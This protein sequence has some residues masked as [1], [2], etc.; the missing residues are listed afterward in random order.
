MEIT[1]L[2]DILPHYAAH[3]PKDDALAG[4]EN[5]VWTKYSINQ[6]IET[7]NNVCYGFMQLGIQKGDRIASI[8]NNRPEW[9]IL[10]MAIMQL[11]CIHVSIYPT[12][13]ETDYQYILH[14]AEVKFVFVA[15]WELLRKIEHLL[16]EIPNLKDNVYTFKNLRG[17]KHLNE[18]IELGKAN[19]SPQYL[20][21]I[22]ESIKPNDVMTIIYTSGTTGKPKGV[23]LTHESIL[24]NVKAVAPITPSDSKS[25]ALSYLPLCHA[26]E[27]MMIYTWQYVGAS[28]YYAENLATIADNLKELQPELF[29]SVPRLLEKFYDRILSMGNKQKGLKRK[30]FFWANDIALAYE[31]GKEKKFWY[32]LKLRIARR[33]VLRKWEAGLGG[34]LRVIVTGGAAIQPRLCR[35]FHAAEIP[36][37]EGYGATETS[38]VM[39]V[40]NFFEHGMKFATVG[41]PLPGMQ[42]KIA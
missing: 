20:Q 7:V 24:S 25:K 1:R 18:I 14:H 28:V 19:P 42:I 21:D 37:I 34:H 6:Y 15:G 40:N 26:Y 12:I 2:F 36:V 9:N 31:I 3:F 29:T 10:D 32:G 17:Y 11:G 5:G 23:M 13:S 35:I 8:T 33:L 27:R 39:A 4:K 22:K 16:P 38:P 30:I 41:P